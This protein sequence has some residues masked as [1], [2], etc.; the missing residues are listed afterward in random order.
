MHL[1]FGTPSI[2]DHAEFRAMLDGFNVLL[3]EANVVTP[4][5]D[6]KH[7]PPTQILGG[8]HGVSI[9]LLFLLSLSSLE[10]RACSR[11]MGTRSLSS[12]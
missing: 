1:L 11:I 10:P 3:P 12:P 7:Y 5:L 6:M 8:R 9:F 2:Y 4:A